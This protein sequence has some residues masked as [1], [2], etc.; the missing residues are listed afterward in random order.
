VRDGI[1][2]AGG[3]CIEEPVHP[4]QET[5]KRPT[6]M[7]DRTLAYLSLVETLLVIRSTGRC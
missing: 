1:I 6:A 4:I 7:L 3:T 2:A 5:G